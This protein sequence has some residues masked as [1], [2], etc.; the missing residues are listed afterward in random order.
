MGSVGREGRRMKFTENQ[1]QK[2]FRVSTNPHYTSITII[3]SH[4]CSILLETGNSYL[5]KGFFCGH[6]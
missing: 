2:D 1:G 4:S 6:N 5:S 3:A